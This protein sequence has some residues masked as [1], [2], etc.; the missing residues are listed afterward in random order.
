MCRCMS[1]LEKCLFR[2]STIFNEIFFSDIEFHEL[3]MYFVF[4]KHFFCHS[5]L[6][7]RIRDNDIILSGIVTPV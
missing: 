4:H 3:F 5:L 2:S 1:S 7:K 6:F